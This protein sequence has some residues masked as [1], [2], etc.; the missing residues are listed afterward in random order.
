[1]KTSE[2]F[3]YQTWIKSNLITRKQA[4]EI[5]GQSY[6]AFSQT[7]KLGQVKPFVE[8]GESGPS[9]VRLYLKSDIEEY[10]KQLKAKK[11]KHQ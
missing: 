7:I 9:I 6:T 10:A 8:L 11:Q 5:T 4:A 3:D 1:M 2:L